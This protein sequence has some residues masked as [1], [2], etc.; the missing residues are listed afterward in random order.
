MDHEVFLCSFKTCDHPL[1]SLWDQFGL[2][3]EKKCKSD[4]A[5]MLSF[6]KGLFFVPTLSTVMIQRILSWGRQKRLSCYKCHKTMAE[7]AIFTF[8]I[9]FQVR[10]AL[11]SL[12]GKKGRR[13]NFKLKNPKITLFRYIYYKINTSTFWC[14]VIALGPCS[15]YTL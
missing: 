8:L 7:N 10:Q 1:T 11:M 4:H 9:I 14:M 12:R 2:H 6:T 13:S 15:V 3:Q 5:R